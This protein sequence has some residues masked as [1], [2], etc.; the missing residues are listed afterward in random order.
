[1]GLLEKPLVGHW[2]VLKRLVLLERV[3]ERVLGLER[4]KQVLML[5]T[6]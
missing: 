2:L 5:V 3:L 4:V 1:L 6:K